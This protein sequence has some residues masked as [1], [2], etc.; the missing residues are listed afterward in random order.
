[1]FIVFFFTFLEIFYAVYSNLT[2]ILRHH[3]FY[4]I[5]LKKKKTKKVTLFLSCSRSQTTKRKQG[6]YRPKK[7]YGD[8][9]VS[10]ENKTLCDRTIMDVMK[11][12][13]IRHH[14]HELQISV[15]VQDVKKKT[16][17][18]LLY[19]RNY[20]VLNKWIKDRLD[21]CVSFKSIFISFRETQLQKSFNIRIKCVCV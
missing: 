16:V 17:L 5:I 1:M 4:H 9:W 13:S 3:I 21:Y 15:L 11:S 20:S 7:N 8:S 12:A 14:C 18:I 19:N 6:S 2:I 10:F